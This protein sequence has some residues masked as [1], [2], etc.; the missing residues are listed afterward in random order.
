V[1]YS[2]LMVATT[3][4][5]L[6]LVVCLTGLPGSSRLRAD[7]PPR[8]VII[9]SCDGLRHDAVNRGMMPRLEALAANGAR[10][11]VARTILPSMTLPAHASMLTGLVPGRHGLMLQNSYLP[12]LGQIRA[13]NVF[14][15]VA[16]A[17]WRAVAIVGK[18]KLWHLA[19][20]CD[21]F[22]HVA[23][24][25]ALFTDTVLRRIA[26]EPPP[27]LLFLHFSEPDSTGHRHGWLSEQQRTA[28]ADVDRQL[29]RL[30]DAVT[31]QPWGERVAWIITADHGGQGRIH[32][33][34]L[35][36]DLRI[37]WIA[38][39]AGIR[40]QTLIKR[41]VRIFDTAAT[42]LAL[43]GLKAPGIDGQVV[44]EALLEALSER[45]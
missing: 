22:L 35:E 7:A 23:G 29:G 40:S 6:W 15:H 4:R 36:V 25:P 12:E 24:S 41:E 2:T 21:P 5:A 45:K 30:L 42:A 43:L 1:I 17:G 11:A 39:G 26:N 8:H 34:P 32:G 13:A 27:A 18:E 44:S 33:T 9:V 20:G 37:P 16:A 10:A 38:A 3:Y 31:T 19:R 14:T 28:I